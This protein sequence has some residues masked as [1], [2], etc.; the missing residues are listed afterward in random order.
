[1]TFFVRSVMPEGYVVVKN[2]PTG[3]KAFVATVNAVDL[4]GTGMAL[5]AK[6]VAGD[7]AQRLNQAAP[8]VRRGGEDG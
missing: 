1:M 2:T 8:L 7:L 3:D 6:Q 4:P 5:D